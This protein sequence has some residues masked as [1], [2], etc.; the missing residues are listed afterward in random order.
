MTTV[1]VT[2][3]LSWR[4][5][6][7]VGSRLVFGE[8]VVGIAEWWFVAPVSGWVVTIRGHGGSSTVPR[9]RV[10]VEVFY[11]QLASEGTSNVGR[12]CS[13]RMGREFWIVH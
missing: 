13:L 1:L 2:A 3:L 8:S 5:S 4:M 11:L 6:V 7:E 12:C 9:R 10:R